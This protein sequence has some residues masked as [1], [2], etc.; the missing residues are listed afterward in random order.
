MFDRDQFFGHVNP[1]LFE[2]KMAS[3]QK[4]GMVLIL[5]E[6]D[7]RG[8]TDFRWLAY[9]LATVY[10]ECDRTMQPIRE[11][12][13][14]HARYAPYYGRG[15]VQL[16]WQA[17]Y[18]KASRFVG[19]DLVADPDRALDP[20]IAVQVLF[21]GMLDGWFTATGKKL[22]DYDTTALAFGYDYTG[23][24]HIINGTDRAVVIAGL[25]F[26]FYYCIAAAFSTNKGPPPTPA[27]APPLN[28]ATFEPPK[29]LP[30]P[31]LART[32][33]GAGAAVV[34]VG[35]GV[36]AAHHFDFGLLAI[37]FCAAAALV[38]LAYLHLKGK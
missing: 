4:S 18:A 33:S 5:D 34:A 8:L 19:V 30:K 32:T 17:N 36:A 28:K 1:T 10:W 21:D 7:K 6:W 25:A 9:M 26:K 29:P 16:T 22:A 14:T 27:T 24:R 31:T 2:G 35:A 37:A 3:T 12:G 20:P 13:G 11:I 15:F 23:A 38:L